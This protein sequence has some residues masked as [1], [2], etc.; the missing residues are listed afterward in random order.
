MNNSGKIATL[1]S[2][3]LFPLLFCI[4]FPVIGGLLSKFGQSG[5]KKG[6]FAREAFHPVYLRRRI[7]GACW[8][9]LYYFKPVYAVV[10]AIPVLKKLV[11]R[12]YGYTESCE[13]VVYPDT[14]IR[15]LPILKVG[16]GS[17]LSNRATIG[18]NI[19]LSDGSI[20]VD[21][22][23]V[24][25]KGLVGHLAMLAPGSKVGAGAE[26]GVGVAVG[27]RTN[28]KDGASIKPSCSLNHGSIIGK[29]ADI[30]TMSYIGLRCEIGDGLKIP[31]GANIPAGAIL[32]TQDEVNQLY[33][34]ETEKLNSHRQALE[35][36]LEKH[37]IHAS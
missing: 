20:F 22:I 25:E 8:T 32:R 27:I 26:I 19:C 14:W 7:Y 28:V 15:D 35:E 12:L 11:L 1:A 36:I 37:N 5:I 18:T 4:A 29:G 9:Q 23:R 17:Y 24:Q 13:F 10:L 3:G 16:K 31:A 6:K 34:L 30:G 2:I 21:S 33:S